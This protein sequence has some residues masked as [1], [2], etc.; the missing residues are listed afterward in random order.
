MLRVLPNP[1]FYL[2]RGEKL[3]K[4]FIVSDVHG[5]FDKMIASLNKEGFDKNNPQHVFISCGDLLD[6]G[7]MP[8]ECLEYVL[9]LPR[10]ILIRGNHEDLLQQAIERHYFCPHDFHN[11]TVDTAYKLAKE[12][13]DSNSGFFS[14]YDL[15]IQNVVLEKLVTND[16]WN[17]YYNQTIDYAETNKYVFT[18]GWVPVDCEDWRKGDWESARWINGME[19]NSE[20]LNPTE[21]TI[22]CGH[23][24]TSWG[25]CHLHGKGPEF[26]E[27][28]EIF[29]N[30]FGKS[31]IEHAHFE[32][33]KDKG[34]IA[35]D[36]CTAYSEKVN[37]LVLTIGKNQLKD[38]LKG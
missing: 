10:R 20:G 22:I 6:R 33:F 7:P 29:E 32:P 5:Y 30:L 25:H 38:Y 1:H 37:C 9:S 23:F 16:L 15:N 14:D 34:I 28:V 3:L 26:D 12:K 8:I 35:I 17:S 13:L 24:H 4:C 31:N 2:K 11:M 27:D 18:H 21:K 19:Y 36:A